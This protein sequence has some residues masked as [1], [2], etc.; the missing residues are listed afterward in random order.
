MNISDFVPSLDKS[1]LGSYV[2]T[3]TATDLAGNVT[4]NTLT[5][6]VSDNT[7][8][9]ISIIGNNPD[10]LLR[11]QVYIDKG[12]TVFDYNGEDVEERIATSDY[13][14]LALNSDSTIQYSDGSATNKADNVTRT[15]TVFDSSP[16]VITSDIVSIIS[17]DSVQIQFDKP[18][19]TDQFLF[20]AVVNSYLLEVLDS[21][22]TI[23]H[24]KQIGKNKDFFDLD[25]SEFPPISNSVYTIKLYTIYNS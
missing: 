8:S 13:N 25:T 17:G 19:Y 1:T 5:V 15:V 9:I 6:I 2:K 18:N 22:Q 16:P 4:S 3:Y 12:A 20:N 23:I 11:N 21:S 14:K 7:K 10:Y 24:S